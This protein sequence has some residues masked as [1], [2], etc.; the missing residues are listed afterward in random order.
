MDYVGEPE[1]RGMWGTRL[2]ADRAPQRELGRR[3]RVGCRELRRRGVAAAGQRGRQP[4]VHTLPTDAVAA[5]EGCQRESSAR[6]L[7]EMLGMKR[8]G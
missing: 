5:A 1:V 2:Q 7:N 6:R 3:R 8:W 4:A